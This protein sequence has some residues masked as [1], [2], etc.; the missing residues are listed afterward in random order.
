MTLTDRYGR[1]WQHEAPPKHLHPARVWTNGQT[2]LD[3][4]ELERIYGPCEES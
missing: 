4:D 2:Y 3:R 1:Q